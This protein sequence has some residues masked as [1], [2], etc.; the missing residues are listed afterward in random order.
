ML[1]ET[2][3]WNE[4]PGFVRVRR[5]RGCRDYDLTPCPDCGGQGIAHCCDGICEQPESHSATRTA[6]VSEP[7][8]ETAPLDLIFAAPGAPLATT[9]GL[10]APA[11][12]DA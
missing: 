4:R 9:A 12:C 7:R 10:G 1:C 11:C 2:C 6:A 8:G 5:T 3:R